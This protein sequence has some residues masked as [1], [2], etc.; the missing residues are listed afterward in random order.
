MDVGPIVQTANALDICTC[1]NSSQSPE[2]GEC[3][4]DCLHGDA[5]HPH[6]SSEPDQMR[7]QIAEM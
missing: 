6:T 5:F 4:G 3:Q 1:C 7:A 2:P